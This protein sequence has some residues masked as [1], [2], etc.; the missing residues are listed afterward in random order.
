MLRASELLADVGRPALVALVTDERCGCGGVLS[1][2]RR[3]CQ[4]R[5]ALSPLGRGRRC[6]RAWPSRRPPRFQAS[7]PS[8]SG[9]TNATPAHRGRVSR[10]R[11]PA[12]IF[13]RDEHAG[14]SRVMDAWRLKLLPEWIRTASQVLR[15]FSSTQPSFRHGHAE[16]METAVSVWCTRAVLLA[17]AACDRWIPHRCRIL[18]RQLRPTAASCSFHPESAANRPAAVESPRRLMCA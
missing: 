4:L 1:I 6:Q 7:R 2:S 5:S 10:T 13:F 8:L 11:V 18:E 16:Q 12:C 14:V 15:S 9:G 17:V 3:S